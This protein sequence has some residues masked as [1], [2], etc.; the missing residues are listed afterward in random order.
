MRQATRVSR[1]WRVRRGVVTVA[2][3]ILLW[4]WKFLFGF[5]CPWGKISEWY[6][7]LSVVLLGLLGL[8]Y[9][10][11]RGDFEGEIKLGGEL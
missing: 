11:L 3:S 10:F 1:V 2:R 6:G 8:I 9:M 5:R 7:I 4:V